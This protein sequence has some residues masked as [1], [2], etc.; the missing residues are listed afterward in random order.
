MS[1][2]VKEELRLMILDFEIVTTKQLTKYPLLITHLKTLGGPEA[3]THN[4]VGFVNTENPIVV[5]MNDF[6]VQFCEDSLN[7]QSENLPEFNPE[8]YRDFINYE[9][10][11]F[12]IRTVSDAGRREFLRGY[13]REMR[14]NV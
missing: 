6:V 10:D 8:N 7:F 3:F 2:M 4:F 12:V 11:T 13:H 14:G 5:F 1:D 9:E